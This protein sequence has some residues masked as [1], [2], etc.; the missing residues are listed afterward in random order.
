MLEN[1]LLYLAPSRPSVYYGQFFRLS[2]FFSGFWP[3][4]CRLQVGVGVHALVYTWYDF[5]LPFMD[6]PSYTSRSEKQP[7]INQGQHIPLNISCI[8]MITSLA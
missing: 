4:F 1:N 6:Y 8:D 7:Q 2:G 5:H 3:S